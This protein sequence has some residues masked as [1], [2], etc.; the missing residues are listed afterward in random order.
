MLSGHLKTEI[1]YKNYE[2]IWNEQTDDVYKYLHTP[3]QLIWA[4]IYSPMWALMGT[5]LR[6]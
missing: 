1:L 5:L 6:P 4:V 2:M 3:Q